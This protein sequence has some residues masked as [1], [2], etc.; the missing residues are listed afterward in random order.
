MQMLDLE[1][2]V[3]EGTPGVADEAALLQVY[4]VKP[5]HNVS[6]HLLINENPSFQSCPQNSCLV[7]SKLVLAICLFPSSCGLNAH[8]IQTGTSASLGQK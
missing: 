2:A 3:D 6:H 7:S 5:R 1:V 4:R 8:N